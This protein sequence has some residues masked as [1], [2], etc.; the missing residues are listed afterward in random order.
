M[1]SRAGRESKT[2]RDPGIGRSRPA[3]WW[4]PS[5]T[6]GSSSGRQLAAWLGLVP[7]SIPAG[8]AHAA[9]H[10]QAGDV[11]LRT[12]L[13]HGARAVVR[14]TERRVDATDGW[15]KRLL[16]RRN[17]NVA[18]VAFGQQECPHRLG[19]AWRAIERS[20]PMTCR[21]QSAYQSIRA[22]KR[23]IPGRFV[24]TIAPGNHDVMAD[25][26]Q[27]AID[28]PGI[29]HGTSFRKSDRASIGVDSIRDRGVPHSKSRMYGR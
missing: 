3:P 5:A 7:G 17:Q 19:A 12:L 28:S 10:R 1:A 2:G 21:R 6:R 24:P 14:V 29:H 25:Q 20:G 13:I 22:H 8:Q 26:V 11:Y 15:L 27:T 16:G 4:P 18:A 9:G 23:I